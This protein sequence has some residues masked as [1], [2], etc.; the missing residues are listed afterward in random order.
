MAAD[1]SRDGVDL[2]ALLLSGDIDALRLRLKEGGP[3]TAKTQPATQPAFFQNACIPPDVER[4]QPSITAH[5]SLFADRPKLRITIEGVSLHLRG[6]RTMGKLLWPAGH[7]IAKLLATAPAP[8]VAAALLEFGAGAGVPSLIAAGSG[9]F[10][11]GVVA[12]D[13]FDENVHLLRH[14]DELNGGK[15]TAA[16]LLDV[17]EKG[18]LTALVAQHFGTSAPCLLVACDMSYDPDAISNIFASGAHVLAA[19]EEADPL[20][21]F[22]RSDNFSHLD[23]HQGMAAKRHGFALVGTADVRAAGALDAIAE[24]HL[25]PCAEDRVRVFLWAR[26]RPAAD[27]AEADAAASHPLATWL[28][29]AASASGEPAPGG[30]DSAAAADDEWAPRAPAA[31]IS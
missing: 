3:P 26:H 30:Q 9:R 23:D 6:V 8:P 16:A 14:H 15:L 12:T 22:A 1:L 24:T 10:A 18:A 31:A 17:W 27:G 28:L 2:D 11:R 5:K 29:K 7:A 21:C 20:V 25:T 4:T 19:S 13:A